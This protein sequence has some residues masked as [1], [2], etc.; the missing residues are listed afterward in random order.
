[1]E[2]GLPSS[3]GKGITV[4]HPLLER[5]P[6]TSHSTE[7]SDPLRA[8]TPSSTTTWSETLDKCLDFSAPPSL[9]LYNGNNNTPTLQCSCNRQVHCCEFLVSMIPSIFVL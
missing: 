2:T 6:P 3:P 7:L 5:G 9:P 1:M 8:L 4:P